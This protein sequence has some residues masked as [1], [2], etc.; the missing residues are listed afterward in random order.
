M[1]R[2]YKTIITDVYLIKRNYYSSTYAVHC[3]IRNNDKAAV[4]HIF[5]TNKEGI[6]Y[7][8]SPYSMVGNNITN[9]NAITVT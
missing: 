2:T 6:Q 1:H 3:T 9:A 5:D 7:E 8:K 4:L